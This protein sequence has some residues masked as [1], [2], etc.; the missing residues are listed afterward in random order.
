MSKAAIAAVAVVSADQYDLNAVGHDPSIGSPG[1]AGY[2]SVTTAAAGTAIA[3]SYTL[4]V[5]QSTVSAMTA[6]DVLAT[7]SVA[8]TA[9][10]VNAQ[11]GVPL[12]QGVITK[13]FLALRVT[14]VGGTAP[15][16]A[17]S[18]Y[19]VPRDIIPVNKFFTK[20]YTTI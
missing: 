13:R 2:F 9:C 17:I 4:E 7:R 10:T 14:A 3:T 18:G 5:I 20:V 19:L 11:F 6:P 16:L 1:L 15:T 12:A 8:G